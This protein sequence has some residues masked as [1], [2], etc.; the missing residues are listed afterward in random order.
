M[1][2]ATCPACD[3]DDIATIYDWMHNSHVVRCRSCGEMYAID[4]E[5][6]WNLG[7]GRVLAEWKQNYE[8]VRRLA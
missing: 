2:K 3:S 6:L 5:D 1:T 7:E 4:D 8:S